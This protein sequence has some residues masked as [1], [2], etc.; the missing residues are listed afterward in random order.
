MKPLSCTRTG[1]RCYRSHVAAILGAATIRPGYGKLRPYRC[2][3]C[4][5]FH[6]THQDKRTEAL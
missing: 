6:L 1:K 5:W 4:G 3:Y 2:G